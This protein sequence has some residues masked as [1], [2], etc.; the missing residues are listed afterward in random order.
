VNY[1]Y[2]R[3]L[4]VVFVVVSWLFSINAFAEERIKPLD[5]SAAISHT[6]LFTG[7]TE[8]EKDLLKL[9]ATLQ[10]YR[11]G[12][13]IVEHG[14]TLDRLFVIIDGQ[15]GVMVDGKLVAT[16]PEQ[17][18]VGELEFLDMLPAIAE[19]TLLKE[20][21]VIELNNNQLRILMNKHP[22][23]GYK[24]MSEIAKIEA[25]RL[26]AMDEKRTD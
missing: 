19:V 20:T 18:L 8:K 25:Q 4:S 13:R 17:S 3:G 9:V 14:Q 11:E 23:I 12:E 2:I 16:L 22:Q 15:A 24:L 21:Y 5:L 10:L 7:L 1:R 26:R 6:S